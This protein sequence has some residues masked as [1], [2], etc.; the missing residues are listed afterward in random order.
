MRAFTDPI[1]HR[2]LQRL[3]AVTHL[4]DPQVP[5]QLLAEELAGTARRR[6]VSRSAPEARNASR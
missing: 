1:A 5:K 2:Q 3:V 6:R 4:R